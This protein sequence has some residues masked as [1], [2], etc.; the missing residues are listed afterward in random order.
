MLYWRFVAPRLLP[1]Q[2]SMADLL[3]DKNQLKFLSESVV[4]VGSDLIGRPITGVQLFKREGVR[5]MDVLRGDLSLRR[6]LPSV[7]L[8]ASERVELRSQVASY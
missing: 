5:L 1:D 3:V 6:D 7:M 8:E 2:A 4:L